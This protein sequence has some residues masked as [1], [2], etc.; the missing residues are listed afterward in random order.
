MRRSGAAASAKTPRTSRKAADTPVADKA[1]L[2]RAAASTPLPKGGEAKEQPRSS[3]RGAVRRRLSS[4]SDKSPAPLR[5]KSPA[6]P[7]RDAVAGLATPTF[8][9]VVLMAATAGLAALAVPYCQQ[10]DCAELARNLPELATDAAAGLYA[11]AHLR[12]QAARQRLKALALHESSAALLAQARVRAQATAD[13]AMEQLRSLVSDVGRHTWGCPAPGGML[14]R[15][16]CPGAAA[17]GSG[18]AR[19]RA[20]P[21]RLQLASLR[22]GG[23]A[24]APSCRFDALTAL[25]YVMPVGEQF[26]PLRHAA[27]AALSSGGAEPVDKVRTG[28]PL[29][30]PGA[31]APCPAAPPSPAAALRARPPGERSVAPR[32]PAAAPHPQAV[33]ALLVCEAAD[34]CHSALHLLEEAVPHSGACVLH[35]DAR[36]LGADRGALQ[37][38]LAAFL[39]DAPDGVVLLRRIDQV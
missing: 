31:C 23:S 32:R 22:K 2:L 14:L 20:L 29:Q 35:L 6:P 11:H 27:A 15:F 37:A 5:G 18:R 10:N 24:G 33:A 21:R 12:V 25:N 7:R 28:P 30:G 39:A 38:Q 8:W 13:A 9:L 3:E 34:D 16:L 1:A 17:A 4:R 36:H 26:V 19:C